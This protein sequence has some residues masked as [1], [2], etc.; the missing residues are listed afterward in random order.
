MQMKIA[1]NIKGA[2]GVAI[3]QELWNSIWKLAEK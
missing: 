3:K 2:D 1:T